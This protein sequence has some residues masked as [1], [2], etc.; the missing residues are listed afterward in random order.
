MH[1]RGYKVEKYKSNTKSQGKPSYARTICTGMM[2]RHAPTLFSR[3]LLALGL[4]SLVHGMM[5]LEFHTVTWKIR[6]RLLLLQGF[7][8]VKMSF[9][10]CCFNC[11][12]YRQQWIKH[13]QLRCKYDNLRWFGNQCALHPISTFHLQD[14]FVKLVTSSCI[15]LA[16]RYVGDMLSL[17]KPRVVSVFTWL[18][19][20]QYYSIC[21]PWQPQ[22]WPQYAM[23]G[24]AW[25][26]RNSDWTKY[27]C[28]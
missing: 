11:N 22:G 2:S 8:K 19:P 25:T 5:P 4:C 15:F 27:V 18:A 14:L 10:K 1:R 16:V 28:T 6:M 9:W 17:E 23:W 26:P 7:W 13:L 20:S 3:M 21:A 24:S 12:I